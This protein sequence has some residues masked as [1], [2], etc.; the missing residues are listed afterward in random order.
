MMKNNVVKYS[1]L[2]D[3]L[4]KFN[5]VIKSDTAHQ[6]CKTNI[7]DF[8]RKR[9]MPFNLLTY[10]VIFRHE[11]TTNDEL[12]E[13]S[14]DFII[15]DAD[16]ITKQ[17]LNKAIKKLNP[18]A[19]VYLIHKFAEIFYAS[20]LPKKYKG[21]HLIAEDGTFLDIPNNIY[22]LYDFGYCT[23]QHVKEMD[24]VKKI[25]S[26]AG[27]LYDVNN[28]FFLDFSLKHANCSETPI[29]FEHLYRTRSLLQDEDVIYLADR[30]YGSAEIISMLEYLKYNY[31]IRGKKNFYKKQVN[32]MTCN[33]EWIEVEIDK[34]WI[35]RFK[36]S[37]DASHYRA[38]NPTMKLRV[39]KKEY[40]YINQKG[41]E[42]EDTLIYFTN[43]SEDKFT[44]QE[45]FELY[46]KRWNIEVAYKILKSVQEIERFISEDGDAARCCIYGKIIFYNIFGII[47]KELDELLDEEYDSDDISEIEEKKKKYVTN[48]TQL[49][50]KVIKKKI[51]FLMYKGRFQDIRLKIISIV[52][53][54][55]RLKVPVRLNRHYKRWGK[56]VSSPPSYRFR[57]DGRNNPKVTRYK[58]VLVTIAP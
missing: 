36:F 26:K 30:Y 49:R 12:T 23:N 2:A 10:F 28:G 22:N 34:K 31:V 53:K 24:D 20:G 35:K 8:S 42:V 19:F 56:I 44:A 38:E 7:S 11:K 39:I 33:D 32:A 17:A 37:P 5:D 13:F 46:S 3:V 43:L 4:C 6:L 55:N 58:G 15:P 52:A 16:E 41:K 25:Q 51:L 54:I 29:A 9:S 57:L 21:Y 40:K 14:E 50:K 27:G 18:N 47:R 1:G 48:I 45:I